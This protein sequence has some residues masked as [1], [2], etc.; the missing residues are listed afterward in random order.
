MLGIHEGYMKELLM[1]EE[2]RNVSWISVNTFLSYSQVTNPPVSSTLYSSWKYTVFI[3]LKMFTSAE[4]K[5]FVW[6][7][8][9]W[10]RNDI[11]YFLRIQECL[12]CPEHLVKHHHL[13]A[14]VFSSTVLKGVWGNLYSSPLVKFVFV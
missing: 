1:W 14:V 4:K 7:W 5:T 6:T 9:S 11:A 12:N 13:F 2:C 3:V 10:H 8:V